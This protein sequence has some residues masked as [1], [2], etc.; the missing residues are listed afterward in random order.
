MVSTYYCLLVILKFSIVLC[1]R[2]TAIRKMSHK[3]SKKKS[4]ERWI[5]RNKWWIKREK[6]L[7]LGLIGPFFTLLFFL[8]HPLPFLSAKI[9]SAAFF[10]LFRQNSCLD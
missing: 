7:I 3:G 4:I 6:C 10:V 1:N 8:L 5:K 2:I 9:L